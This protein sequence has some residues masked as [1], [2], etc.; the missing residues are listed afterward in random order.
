LKYQAVLIF[1]G[2]SSSLYIGSEDSILQQ[3]SATAGIANHPALISNGNL[4]YSGLDSKQA[5]VK[6]YRGGIGV[7]DN[8][9]YLVIARSATVPDLAYVMR[10]LG[11]QKALNLDGGGSSALYYDGYKVGPGRLLPNAI[12][13]AE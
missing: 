1:S 6:S 13:F 12:V 9:I 10:S 7:K 5:N 11:V 3:V 2:K 8:Y 4:A